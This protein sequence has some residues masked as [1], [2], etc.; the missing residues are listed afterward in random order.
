MYLSYLIPALFKI[1]KVKIL[2]THTGAF[3]NVM[4]L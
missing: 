1:P 2:I 4:S 3:Q